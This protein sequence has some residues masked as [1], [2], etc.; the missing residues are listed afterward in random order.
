[1]LKNS[2][3]VCLTQSSYIVLSFS[4]KAL[5]KSESV[6]IWLFELASFNGVILVWGILI[7]FFVIFLLLFPLI[8]TCKLCKR[9]NPIVEDWNCIP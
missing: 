5:E 6:F 3:L 7:S 9:Q 8:F 2:A 1:M 4:T